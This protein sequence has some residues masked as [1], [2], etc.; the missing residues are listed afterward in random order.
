MARNIQ[1]LT[2]DDIAEL[3]QF[4]T[5]GFNSLPEADFAVPEVLRGS[6]WKIQVSLAREVISH[7]MKAA[8]LS[9]I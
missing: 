1:A 5:A 6:I 7:A 3:S 8:R 9:A 4:L 2:S